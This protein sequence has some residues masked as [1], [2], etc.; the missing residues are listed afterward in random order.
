MYIVQKY[1]FN[2]FFNA[3]IGK[4]T[5]EAEDKAIAYKEEQ[6]RLGVICHIKSEVD[7]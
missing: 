2:G 3:Y 7:R 5:F 4:K 1:K 6:I